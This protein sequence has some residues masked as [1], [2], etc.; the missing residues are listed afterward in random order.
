MKKKHILQ[1]LLKSMAV[2]T[3]IGGVVFQVTTAPLAMAETVQVTTYS[4]SEEEKTALREYTEAKISLAMQ[5][6]YLAFFEEMTTSFSEFSNQAWDSE[7][8][9]IS[10]VLS[11]EQASLLD[12]IKTTYISS[13]GEHYYYL[14]ETL[15]ILGKSG[16]EE[17]E[18]I[19]A[20][21][22]A[23]AVDNG[24]EASLEAELAALT[25]TKEVILAMLDTNHQ[26]IEYYTKE[27][28][29]KQA[30]LL[31]LLAQE[32]IE[33][34]RLTTAVVSHAQGIATASQPPFPYDFTEMD[35]RIAEL[36]A[37]LQV[38]DTGNFQPADG[39][40]G[41]G[42]VNP[43][44]QQGVNQ[45]VANSGLGAGTGEVGGLGGGAAEVPDISGLG[46]AGASTVLGQAKV[47]P[48]PLGSQ[49]KNLP[50]TSSQREILL[51][52]LGFITGFVSFLS[53][54]IKKA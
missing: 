19:V 28:E 50:K 1:P 14:L 30:D 51:I 54:K 3:L 35:K 34:D 42:L 38:A 8:V 27:S 40:S 46:L 33:A 53:F 23:A 21:Y 18:A 49:S 52:L 12:E 16:R 36:T 22:E 13:I 37:Q 11:P 39:Q 7:V 17:A 29:R 24:E 15:T 4:L 41:T 6:F 9:D 45:E 32:T 31:A 5:E 2:L 48:K 47:F 43:E 25:Y 20:N 44:S 10:A 26:A